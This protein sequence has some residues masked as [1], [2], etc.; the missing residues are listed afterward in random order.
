[1]KSIG[2]ILYV[3]DIEFSFDYELYK[4]KCSII[5]VCLLEGLL[6]GSWGEFWGG[7]LMGLLVSVFFIKHAKLSI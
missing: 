5:K 3:E 2:E 6:A 4:I 1:M 7:L